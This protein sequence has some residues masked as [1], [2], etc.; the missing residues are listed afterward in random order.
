MEGG[1]HVQC[2]VKFARDD[3]VVEDL[4]P[5][6][7]HWRLPVPDEAHA[8]LHE[9]TDVEVVGVPNVRGDDAAAAA[10][11]HGHDHLVDGLWDVCLK[12]ERLLDL[13]HDALRL[14]EGARV[15]GDVEPAWDDLLELLHDVLV[16]RE[17][18]RLD[19]QLVPGKCQTL[20]NAV[21]ADDT[22]RALREGPF[23]DTQ[24]DGSQSLRA[25]V[26]DAV[27][28]YQVGHIHS[29]IHQQRLP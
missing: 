9:R 14:V 27:T 20:G 23:G 5:V 8:F 10:L 6:L 26:S 16:L 18:E 13:V 24:A 21:H 12:H 17:V 7:V 29:P 11:L 4:L 1:S 25:K 19:A 22:L 28:I 3:P 2:W 15:D